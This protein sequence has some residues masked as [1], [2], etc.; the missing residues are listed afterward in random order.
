MSLVEE[1][2]GGDVR[3]YDDS[4]LAAVLGDGSGA[5]GWDPDAPVLGEVMAERPYL[6][7]FRDANQAARA[8]FLDECA[9]ECSGRVCV[10]LIGFWLFV[11]GHAVRCARRDRVEQFAELCVKVIRCVE[12]LL[13]SRAFSV[14]ISGAQSINR[15]FLLGYVEWIKGCVEGS[16]LSI[17]EAMDQYARVIARV[18]A[19]RSRPEQTSRA[20][21]Q[22]TSAAMAGSAD[23]VKQI[24]A[25]LVQLMASSTIFLQQ[26]LRVPSFV[27]ERFDRRQ[28]TGSVQVPKRLKTFKTN[29]SAASG[30]RHLRTWKEQQGALLVPR[31]EPVTTGPFDF[32]ERSEDE[33]LARSAGRKRARPAATEQPADGGRPAARR[34]IN[35]GGGAGSGSGRVAAGGRARGAAEQTEATRRRKRQR[36]VVSSD[37]EGGRGTDSS[38]GVE[39]CHV[40]DL[41]MPK[42]MSEWAWTF[43]LLKAQRRF[44]EGQS[45]MGDVE[46]GQRIKN[47]GL[48]VLLERLF[49]GKHRTEWASAGM[50]LPGFG[51]VRAADFNR[52]LRLEGFLRWFPYWRPAYVKYRIYVSLGVFAKAAGALGV[53][54]GSPLFIP[55]TVVDALSMPGPEHLRPGPLLKLLKREGLAWVGLTEEMREINA[56]TLNALAKLTKESC[57]MEREEPNENPKPWPADRIDEAEIVRRQQMA[58]RVREAHKGF[59]QERLKDRREQGMREIR[60]SLPGD[61]SE[62][63]IKSTTEWHSMSSRSKRYLTDFHLMEPTPSMGVGGERAA[64]AFL[65]AED[66]ITSPLQSRTAA[67]AGFVHSGDVNMDRPETEG[68]GAETNSREI[69]AVSKREDRA[70]ATVQGG[71]GVTATAAELAKEMDLMRQAHRAAAIAGDDHEVRRIAPALQALQLRHEKLTDREFL[72]TPVEPRIHPPNHANGLSGRPAERKDMSRPGERI[73]AVSAGVKAGGTAAGKGS[74]ESADKA[75]AVSA[76]PAGRE[77]RPR[78]VERIPAVPVA[79]KVSGTAAGKQSTEST[80]PANAVSGRPTGQKDKPRPAERIPGVPAGVEVGGTAVAPRAGGVMAT[81]LGVLRGS[82]RALGKDPAERDGRESGEEPVASCRTV[83]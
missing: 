34:R 41:M 6:W 22:T 79:E 17:A 30:L 83:S 46:L 5:E 39:F 53:L 54:R 66:P 74:T 35:R 59:R 44:V 20:W 76:R 47:N 82:E 36:R 25:E 1:V 31:S 58:V 60:G 42:I 14:V 73:P 48:V 67:A 52:D 38:F 21:L 40:L 81:A 32:K 55:G 19:D 80:N 68:G 37:E 33:V 18:G 2:G 23:V 75:S 49:S 62:S 50:W 70:A 61:P 72:G 16:Q 63:D 4:E 27:S 3:I 8:G 71:Q 26:R 57:E 15:F 78:P 43:G 28:L 12:G 45:W 77:D 10:Q 64:Q 65:G 7:P 69:G 56:I 29:P 13:E 9:E 51:D 24:E 11:L